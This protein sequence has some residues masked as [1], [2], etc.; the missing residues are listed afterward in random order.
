MIVKRRKFHFN[1][2]FFFSYNMSSSLFF[3]DH[4]VYSSKSEGIKFT[5]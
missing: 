5:H 4:F 3:K 2:G 1:G